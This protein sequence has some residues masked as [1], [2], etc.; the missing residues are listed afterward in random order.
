MRSSS[1]LSDVAILPVCTDDNIMCNVRWPTDGIKDIIGK[2]RL[3]IQVI[4]KWVKHLGKMPY[5]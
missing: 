1:D 2:I 3:M 4:Q 5:E